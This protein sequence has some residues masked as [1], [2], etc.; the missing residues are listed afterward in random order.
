MPFEAQAKAG[1]VREFR[2]T[3]PTPFGPCVA[4]YDKPAVRDGAIVA[5]DGKSAR[6]MSAT[7]R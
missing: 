5:D 6:T 1:R 2:L 4:G 7:V 3:S